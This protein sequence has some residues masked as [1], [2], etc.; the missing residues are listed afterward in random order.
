MRLGV[1]G[2]YVVVGA[3]LGGLFACFG[4]IYLAAVVVDIA[5]EH[6]IAQWV[7]NDTVAAMGYRFVL[8]AAIG[9]VVGA[10]V[11]VWARGRNP[12]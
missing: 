3:L 7:L 6:W 12:R 4:L 1:S 11:C 10:V 9:S 5:R 8:G 2:G